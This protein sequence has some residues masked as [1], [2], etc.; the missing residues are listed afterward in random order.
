MSNLITWKA[1][2][3]IVGLLTILAAATMRQEKQ[4][5]VEQDRVRSFHRSMQNNAQDY[6]DAARKADLAKALQK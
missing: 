6:S 1:L 4:R 5:A 2:A 3:V